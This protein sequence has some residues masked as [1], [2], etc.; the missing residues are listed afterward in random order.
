MKTK[1]LNLVLTLAI[2]L[3]NFTLLQAQGHRS[4]RPSPEERARW[5]TDWMKKELLLDSTVVPRVYAINLKY[6]NKMEGIMQNDTSS[7]FERHQD[8]RNLMD[9]KDNELKKVLTDE[10]YKL[11]LQK[12]NEMRQHARDHRMQRP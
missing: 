11:Y 8:V 6:A 4:Q 9:A 10:Q 7:R 3:V 5:Q 1:A 12:R 2:V